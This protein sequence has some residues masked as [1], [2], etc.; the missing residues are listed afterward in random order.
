MV[1]EMAAKL[2]EE[3]NAAFKDQRYLA[4]AALYT[5][6]LKND[7][8]T[9]EQTTAVLYR[10]AATSAIGM[11]INDLDGNAAP[12]LPNAVPPTQPT[13]AGLHPIVM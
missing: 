4:A 8:G 10:Q 13:F 3:G 6:A 1:A 9:N 2:K 5:K 11:H 7:S 12:T